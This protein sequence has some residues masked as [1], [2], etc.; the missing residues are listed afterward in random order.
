MK[1]TLV[2]LLFVS[3]GVWAATSQTSTGTYATGRVA[4][5][6]LGVGPALHING[7]VKG[8]ALPGMN[9]TAVTTAAPGVPLYVGVDAGF[10]FNNDPK[11]NG[12][13]PV[14]GTMYY[15]FPTGASVRPVLGVCAGPVFGLGDNQDSARFSMLIKPALN[16]HMAETVGLSIESKVGVIGS[17]FVYLPQ[18]S[19][20]FTL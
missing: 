11:F 13:L 16:I 9:F 19:A 20:H 2:T 12:V 7:D 15:E 18:I 8:K 14:L 17:T 5:T 3:S 6:V 1:L 4:N 10:F